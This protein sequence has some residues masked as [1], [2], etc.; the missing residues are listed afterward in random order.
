[1][2]N[3]GARVLKSIFCNKIERER[4][5]LPLQPYY[6]GLSLSSRMCDGTVLMVSRSLLAAAG[7]RG[8]NILMLMEIK[9]PF[10]FE[11]ALMAR[12][13]IQHQY[14]RCVVSSIVLKQRE[15]KNKNT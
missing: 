11:S 4:V 15:C 13:K 6:S 14:T 1:M 12:V 8:S 3:A 5:E 10:F 7:R 2:W 9:I